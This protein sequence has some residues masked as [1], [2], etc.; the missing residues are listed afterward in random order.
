M[1]ALGVWYSIAVLAFLSLGACGE[2]EAASAEPEVA[3]I[4]SEASQ[5]TSEEA[6]GVS[7]PEV[8][9]SVPQTYDWMAELEMNFAAIG[10]GAR[11]HYN[12][13]SPGEC[14]FPP[15]SGGEDQGSPVYTPVENTCCSAGGL[16]GPDTNGDNLCD[17]TGGMNMFCSDSTWTALGFAPDSPHAFTYRF[18]PWV[19]GGDELPPWFSDSN[20]RG[21]DIEAYGDPEC[22]GTPVVYLQTVD[23]G[24]DSSVSGVLMD[25]YFAVCADT[26]CDWESAVQTWH[27]ECGCARDDEPC[28][29]ACAEAAGWLP[30]EPYSCALSPSVADDVWAEGTSEIM[31]VGVPSGYD[32]YAEVETSFAQ[33]LSGAIASY[34]SSPQGDCQFPANQGLTPVEA[35]CCS[36]GGLGGP[37]TNGNNLCDEDPE[38]WTWE[39]EDYP[40]SWDEIGFTGPEGEHSGVY[41]FGS[42]EDLF[43][44]YASVRPQCGSDELEFSQHID[45]SQLTFEGDSCTPT[46]GADAWAAA[47]LDRTMDPP[48]LDATP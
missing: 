43:E 16:G 42:S 24:T 33:I 17:V 23:M 32:V 25:E 37:D 18:V 44:I 28:A 15:V 29:S 36:F 34:E 6:G 10:A 31:L 1:R 30:M 26:E 14:Q 27:E 2:E 46:G 5:S 38:M 9:S 13:S 40:Q 39:S 35:T 12:A 48:V 7:A 19:G 11:A 20:H 47:T 22:D 45:L 3:G 4:C 21:F 41:G 8:R